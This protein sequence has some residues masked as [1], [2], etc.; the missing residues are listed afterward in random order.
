MLESIL[1]STETLTIPEILICSV[2]ALIL[3]F[4]MACVYMTGKNYT[5]NF[6]ITLVLMPFLIGIVIMLVNGNLGTGIAAFGAFG[7]VRFRSIAGTAREIMFIVFETGIGLA[8][9]M[10]FYVFRGSYNGNR[11]R[12]VHSSYKA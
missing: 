2:A 8:V 1:S 10:G 6:I 5:K 4:V 9:G 11:L 12:R 7:L 3:G